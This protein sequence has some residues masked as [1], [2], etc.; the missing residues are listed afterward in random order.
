M[1]Q[2][3]SQDL[4]DRVIEAVA[5]EGMS[6]RAAAQR[7]GISESSAIKWLQRYVQTGGRT[8]MTMGGAH[9]VVLSPH[10][11]FI[12]E[13]LAGKPDLTLAA[14]RRR[15]AEKRGVKT[16]TSVLSRFLRREG[17]SFKKDAGRPRAGP[18]R[19]KPSPCP[20]AEPAK[21]CRSEPAGVHRW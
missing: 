18:A 8:A 1:G 19:H 16:D 14:L 17:L 6:R 10:R 11:S 2:P 5:Q 7:F 4:R 13:A 15:L 12:A 20:V 9:H 3:Y 21:P